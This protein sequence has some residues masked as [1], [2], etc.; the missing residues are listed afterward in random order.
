MEKSADPAARRLKMSSQT[1]TA[2]AI[3]DRFDIPLETQ[4]L[5]LQLCWAQHDAQW[6]LKSKRRLGIEGANE[7]NQEVI[8]SM[9]RIEARHIMNA[10]GIPRDAV[11]SIPEVFRMMNTFMHV[12]APEIMQFDMVAVNEAGGVGLVDKCYVWEEVRRSKGESEY[13]CAC[14]HRHRGW[15]EAMGFRGKIL[16]VSRISDGDERCEFRFIL[17]PVVVR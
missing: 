9:G 15:L 10:L 13:T 2:T 6:F 5:V 1:E 17:Q 16:P 14:N 4:K 3:D 12:I 11:R 8:T 7:L